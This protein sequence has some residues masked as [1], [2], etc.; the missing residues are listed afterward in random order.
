VFLGK[1]F[2]R[3]RNIETHLTLK[4]RQ[5]HSIASPWRWTQYYPSKRSKLLTY[6]RSVTSQDS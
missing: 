1:V 5:Y 6:R 2:S 4:V 3:I